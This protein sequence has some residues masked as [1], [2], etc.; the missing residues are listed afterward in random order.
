MGG[1]GGA[2]PDMTK[3]ENQGREE[4]KDSA[5]WQLSSDGHRIFD[6]FIWS[7]LVLDLFSHYVLN[8]LEIALTVGGAIP[9]VRLVCW[10]S[11]IF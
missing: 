1:E 11:P 5:P 3:C 2:F 7:I 6:F 9:E 8:I 4:N 10:F